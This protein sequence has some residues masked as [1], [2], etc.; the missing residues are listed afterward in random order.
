MSLGCTDNPHHP[1]ATRQST[2][3]VWD[4]AE[5]LGHPPTLESKID[6]MGRPS[7]YLP[8]VAPHVF[9][10][11]GQVNAVSYNFCQFVKRD[12]ERCKR[13]IA[14]GE[15]FCWQHSRGLRTKLRSLTRSQTIG[16]CI[17][18][19]SLVAT[20]WFGVWSLFPKTAPVTHIESSGDQSPNVENNKGQVTIQN[21]QST[22][23][24]ER[25]KPPA[26]EKQ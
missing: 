2:R 19:A 4:P 10:R 22:Q 24:Q 9:V 26:R 13:A 1:P 15:I 21:Q 12:S 6:G 20:L 14:A 7:A 25:K 17:S 5:R 8:R 16:F 11:C 23:E 18:I 3:K